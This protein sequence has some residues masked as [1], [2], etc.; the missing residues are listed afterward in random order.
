MR[1]LAL[2]WALTAVPLM[3]GVSVLTFVLA[4][5]V[6]GDAARSILGIN[7]NPKQY[8][9]LRAQLGL[10][11]PLWTRYWHWLTGAVHGNLGQSTASGGSVSHELVGRLGVTLSL[12]IGAVLFAA[13]VGVALGV[14]SALR[15]GSLGRLVDVVSLLG[16]AVPAFWLGLVLVAFFAVDLTVFPATGYVPFGVSPVRWFESLVLPVVTLGVGAAAPIAKQA[17]DGVLTELGKEYVTVLRAR[18]VREGRIVV[19]HVLRNAGTPVLSVV[20]LV[21]VGLLGGTVLVETVFVMPGLGGLVATATSAHDIP[22]IQGVAVLFT[23]IVVVVNLLVEFGYA[24]LNPKV[25][26]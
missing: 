23:L 8:E 5:L 19:K 2:R 21:V 22:V 3:L 16:L 20:G 12:V 24:A 15:G 7:A 9:Q 11:E 1:K 25:R 13:I 6:P 14:A 10:N 17:R 18:G 4:S 26:S